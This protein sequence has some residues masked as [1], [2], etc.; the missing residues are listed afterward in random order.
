MLQQDTPED[1]VIATGENHSVREFV[2]EAGRYLGIPITWEGKGLKEVGKDQK[3]DIIVEVHER[4]Y[5]PHE[6]DNL[7]GNSKK[8]R[9][10]L[11][12]KP[13][14]DFKC[15]VEMMLESDT[16]LIVGSTEHVYE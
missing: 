1:F 10:K 5:R 7:L 8:A 12:W 16:K 15:L 13:K 11:G 6:V 4:Y 3:G 14:V 9:E 2:E